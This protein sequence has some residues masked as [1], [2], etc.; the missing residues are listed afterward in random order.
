MPL[1]NN[2]GRLTGW[3][4]SLL[5][6]PVLLLQTQTA[7]R[8]LTAED[9]ATHLGV[10]YWETQVD[11]PPGTFRASLVEIT[12]GHLS[13]Q[14]AS[15]A[16]DSRDI[17]GS[18]LTIMISHPPG[19]LKKS[20]VLGAASNRRVESL[21]FK[22]VS[23]PQTLVLPGRIG[24]GDY[25]L[26]GAWKKHNGVSVATGRIADLKYGFLLRIERLHARHA[27]ALS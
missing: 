1:R 7:A 17:N 22:D 18:F 4:A 10:K 14:S 16:G 8:A 27:S 3:L 13:H 24:P 26:G 5:L 21:F 11:L 19:T 15:F 6:V 25:L 23:M 12:N 2:S 20:I 9:L